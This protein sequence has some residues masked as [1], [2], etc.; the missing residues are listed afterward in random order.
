MKTFLLISSKF[1]L[2]IEKSKAAQNTI[3][4]ILK[5]GKNLKR[6]KEVSKRHKER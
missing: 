4:K 2:N 5:D 3:R 1:C 6:H